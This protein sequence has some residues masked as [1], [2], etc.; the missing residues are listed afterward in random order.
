MNQYENFSIASYSFHGLLG[1]GAIDVFGY[2]ETVK[3]RYGLSTADIWNGYIKS[4]DDEFAATL[5]QGLDE[6]GLSV[7]NLCCDDAHVWDN[8]PDYR[9]KTEETA[10]NCLALAE[11]IGAKTIRIDVGVR[12][13]EISDEQLDHVVKKYREYCRRAASFGAKVGTENHWGWSRSVA[14]V[15]QLFDAVDEE[16]FGL[17]LHM[18]NWDSG[19]KDANDIAMA[20]RAMHVHIDFEHCM[21]A[22]RILPPFKAAGYAGCWNVESHKGT[23]EYNN[24]ALQLAQVRRAVCPMEYKKD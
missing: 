15:E 10:W 19:D 22:E 16:N 5:K 3:Y 11:K 21:E 7:V 23:N 13:D 8:D 6:R 17:L 12:E 24:V 18:G 4:Y 14:H 9:A 2:L 20:K 1:R